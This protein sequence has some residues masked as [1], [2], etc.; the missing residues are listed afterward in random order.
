MGKHRLKLVREDSEQNPLY[1]TLEKIRQ[2]D[3]I[4]ASLRRRGNIMENILIAATSILSLGCFGY[5]LFSAYSEDQNKKLLPSQ[6]RRY[7]L[8]RDGLLNA[9]ELYLMEYESK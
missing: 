5:A 4:I 2:D 1:A 8:N 9:E 3:R 6:Y 7:D